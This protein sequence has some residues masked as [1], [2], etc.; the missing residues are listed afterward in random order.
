[1]R[2]IFTKCFNTYKSPEE[3]AASESYVL[4]RMTFSPRLFEIKLSQKCETVAY[5]DDSDMF[6]ITE[7]EAARA[8]NVNTGKVLNVVVARLD[9]Q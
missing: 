8:Y 1:M 7:G 5:F 3:K 9:S 4:N 2:N 6:V